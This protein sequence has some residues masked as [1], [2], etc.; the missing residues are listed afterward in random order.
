MADTPKTKIIV[1]EDN[2]L[3]GDIIVTKLSGSGY[4]TALAR[5][6]PD[7]LKRIQDEHFDLV[8]LDIVLPLMNGYE[9]LENMR[10]DPKTASVPVIII[11]NSGQ[12]IELERLRALGVKDYLI[13]ADFTPEE[14]LAK[15]RAQLGEPTGPMRWP[16]KF[17]VLIVED[18]P[19]LK[20]LLSRKLANQVEVF[21]ATEGEEAVKIFTEKQ[22]SMVLLDILLPGID[23]FEVL[24]RI[25]D[26]PNKSEKL[27]VIVLSNFNQ[28][29][30][31][32]RAIDL[33]ANDYMVKSNFTID[34]ILTKVH[35]HVVKMYPEI[36]K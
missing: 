10:K 6:G 17:S 22:P 12:P 13:K 4:E 3:L 34:E 35:E 5:N 31:M 11:S 25:K 30:D 27:I 32:Q 24:Q 26:T 19:F 15:I 21:Y 8:L 36:E 18:D 14:V 7:A 28:A 2:D 1:V 9:I 23:G 16:A 33:G 20:D 29:Y